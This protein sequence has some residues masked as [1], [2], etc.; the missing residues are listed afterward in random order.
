MDD[1]SRAAYTA[2]LADETAESAIKFLW[3]AIAWYV[4]HGIKVERVLTDNGVCYKPWKFRDVCRELGVKHKRTRPCHPQTNGKAE[5]FIRTALKEWAYAQTY[6]HS[7]KRTAHL[8]VW[9]EYYN[10]QRPH[11]AFGRKPPALAITEGE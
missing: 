11:S 5:R 3:F 4:S 8:P 2:I 9:T 1:V 6:A 7:W 10:F